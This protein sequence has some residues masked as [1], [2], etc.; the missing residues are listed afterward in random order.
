VR[1]KDILQNLTKN[2]SVKFSYS[3]IRKHIEEC[4]A[5]TTLV[6]F[7][8]GSGVVKVGHGE[9]E[10]QLS[11]PDFKWLMYLPIGECWCF[12]AL[13]DPNNTWLEW[14][15]DIS[16]NNFIDEE[17]IPCI[18]DVFLD[19]VILPDG[20]AVTVDADELREALDKG[21]IST[22]DFEN[23]YAVHDKL[24]NSKWSNAKYLKDF[25]NKLLIEHEQ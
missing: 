15:F 23:A 17:G 16:R 20:Q 8:P 10:K 12:T 5:Y 3:P 1:K 13:Y 19:L 14:Y 21:V 2:P 4:E 24:K 18:D 9:N 11:G 25:C 6:T 22:E 7:L